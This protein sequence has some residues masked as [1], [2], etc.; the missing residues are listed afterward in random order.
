MFELEKTERIRQLIAVTKSDS[1]ISGSVL[2]EAHME[3]GME[4]GKLLTEKLP[5]GEPSDT[6]V[7]A[8][9]R[10][11]IFFAAGI[12]FQ[13][14]CRFQLYYPDHEDFIRPETKNI[15]IADS[16]INTGQTIC[17]ILDKD[18]IA[19]CCVASERAAEIFK[20]QLFTVRVSGNSYTGENV[21]RQEGSTGPDTTLRLFNQLSGS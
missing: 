4:L 14:G 21:S 1:G 17:K 3:L 18:M 7:V 19:A 8:V 9:L 6:T 5:S 13:L 15:I 12:Y 20:D 2:A 11:G 10:G 16:V